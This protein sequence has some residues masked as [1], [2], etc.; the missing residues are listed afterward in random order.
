MFAIRPTYLI[1]VTAYMAL[2]DT[3]YG[4]PYN[5]YNFDSKY[6]SM[7]FGKL[8]AGC[9]CLH[10]HAGNG[11]LRNDEIAYYKTEQMTIKYL[12]EIK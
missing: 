8:P 9:T 3:A 5:V 4:K 7:D 10:A 2:F 12:I 1:M 11:M 6:Y